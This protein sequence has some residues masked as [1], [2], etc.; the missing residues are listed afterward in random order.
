MVGVIKFLE[1]LF[2][3]NQHLKDSQQG[4]F[5]GRY[6]VSDLPALQLRFER[7]VRKAKGKK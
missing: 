4:S 6:F 3:E 1:A 2:P 7:L 5:E